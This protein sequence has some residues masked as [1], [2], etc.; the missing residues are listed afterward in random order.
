MLKERIIVLFYIMEGDFMVRIKKGIRIIILLLFSILTSI[1]PINAVSTHTYEAKTDIE[2]Q[3]TSPVGFHGNLSHYYADGELAY[4]I[5]PANPFVEGNKEQTSLESYEKFD[6]SLKQKIELI[7]Y[8]AKKRGA[9]TNNDV[10]ATAQLMI[11]ELVEPRFKVE[12]MEFTNYSHQR[13]LDISSAINFD[14]KNH[15]QVPSFDKDVINLKVGQ[16]ITITDTNS[17]S[18]SFKYHADSKKLSITQNGH[19]LTLTALKSGSTTVN[20]QKI[21]ESNVGLSLVFLDPSAQD[22]A[23][24]KVKN[25][26]ATSFSVNIEELGSLDIMKVDDNN[27]P[28]P[29]TKFKLS[30][31]DSLIGT[32]VTDSTGKVR[33][34]DLVA[35]TYY[36]QEIEVAAPY[37]LESEV[38]EVTITSNETATFTQVNKKVLGQIKLIKEGPEGEAVEGATF[39]LINE[40][41]DVIEQ[42][43]SDNNG[44]ATSKSHPI[45]K[46][47]LVETSVP[48]PYI[49]DQTPIPIHL[50]YV[51][52]VTP[53]VIKTVRLNN[54][55]AKGQF[56]IIKL[57][58]ELK[59]PL[60]N[61]EFEI[62]DA[63]DKLVGTLITDEDGKAVSPELELGTYTIK[64]TVFPLGYVT[65]EFIQT[66]T[67]SYENQK[68]PIVYR[69]HELEN[70]PIKGKIQVVKINSSKE[71]IPV[72]GAKFNVLSLPSREV[73]EQ[74]VTDKN[75]FAITSE[76]RYGDYLIVEIEAPE[77]FYLN[78]HEYPVS[79]KNHNE[80]VIQYIANDLI[81]LK[82]GIKKLDSKTNEPLENAIFEVYDENDERVEFTYLN[83]KHEVINQQQLITNKEGIAYTKGALH[84]GTYTLK[85]VKAP[86]G[87]LRSQPIEFVID[88]NTEAIELETIGRTLVQ[89]IS[90]DKTTTEIRKVDVYGDYLPEASLTLLDENHNE[91]LNFTSSDESFVVKGLVVGETYC[92]IEETAP[93]GYLLSDPVSFIV[94]ESKE[95]QIVEMINELVPTI[96]TH[97]TFDSSIKES[98][99]LENVVIHDL[100]ELD[101]LWQSQMYTVVGKLVDRH[102]QEIISVRELEFEAKNEKMMVDMKFE[103]DASIY[104]SRTLVVTQELYKNNKLVATHTDLMDENQ[105]IRFPK[106]S[107]TATSNNLKEDLPLEK[108][109]ITDRVEYSALTPNQEFMLKGQLVLKEDLS[110]IAESEVFFTPSA[111]SG[112]VELSFEFDGSHLG[113]KE[114][115][116]FETLYNE[117]ILIAQHM[118]SEDKNQTVKILNPTI[119]TSAQSLPRESK[120]PSLISIVDTVEFKDLL[121]GKE[122]TIKGML[123]DKNTNKPFMVDGK[124]I[125]STKTFMAEAS[126]GKIELVF[127]FDQAALKKTT[128]VVFEELYFEQS[129]IA[130][131]KDINDM[132]QSIQF[133]EVKIVKVDDADDSKRLANAEFILV[134]DGLELQRLVTNKDGTL[135]FF[136]ASGSYQLSETQAPRGYQLN[137]NSFELEDLKSSVTLTIPNKVVVPLPETGTDSTPFWYFMLSIGLISLGVSMMRKKRRED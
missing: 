108:L 114:V 57:D 53:L 135:S 70:K 54:D 81:E 72:E 107:T 36:I 110:V 39:N 59:T 109:M 129:L 23:T 136:V 104:E 63:Q 14:I 123:M 133:H 35:G 130:S 56:E 86:A 132:N 15:H 102:T 69:T 40:K 74:I 25:N 71:E 127:T 121:V 2:Y 51:D 90:N 118:D 33:I 8:Y 119:K 46:Y 43:T 79:I 32:Y 124:Q 48:E 1:T 16:S 21:E 64:E 58:S 93:D 76:L 66:I 134:Q 87:Y 45:G 115:V 68:T 98:L 101:N 44:L 11:W 12:L 10:R 5:D 65:D 7:D 83:D 88:R 3:D 75:G 103:I 31:I 92:L 27:K 34:N 24:L 106:I 89:E 113:G 96:K 120:N 28:V 73:V 37:Y 99:P 95:V 18:S 117:G 42:L 30:T 67:L 112:V 9:S 122:Y 137:K 77:E 78:P 128:L 26:V 126:D 131:H 80:T 49:L 55:I 97:A 105:T 100:V 125:T 4:C 41:G 82:L 94:E 111:E 6:D 50:E 13:Y 38:H 47:T 84:Y 60:P 61:V 17:I 29:N 20:G 85:E 52:M 91:I 19:S 62:R 22:I 116:V